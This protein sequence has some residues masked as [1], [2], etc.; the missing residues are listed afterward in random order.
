MLRLCV[1]MVSCVVHYPRTGSLLRR[2][3]D[4]RVGGTRG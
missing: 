4:A 3:S 2:V 1:D